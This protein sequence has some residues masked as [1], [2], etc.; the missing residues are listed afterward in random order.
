MKAKSTQYTLA[1]ALIVIWGF[2]GK[3][4][5][6][7]IKSDRQNGPIVQKFHPVISNTEQDSFSLFLTYDDPFSLTT[8]KASLKAQKSTTN[9][10]SILPF[11]LVN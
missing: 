7:A 1:M 3:Q 2:I 8:N 4:I 5:Y 9:Q 6:G 11:T 10:K